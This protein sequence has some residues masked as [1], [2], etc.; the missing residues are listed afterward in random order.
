M[1]FLQIVAAVAAISALI[2]VID[3]VANYLVEP[4]VEL[5][6]KHA[7]EWAERKIDHVIEL[8]EADCMELIPIEEDNDEQGYVR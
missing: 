4:A 3:A 7:V 1:L 5:E 6:V 8:T 2:A